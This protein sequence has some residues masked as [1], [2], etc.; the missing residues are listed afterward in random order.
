MTAVFPVRSWYPLKH[1]LRKSVLIQ[2][3][4]DGHEQRVSK[5][6]A[7]SRA[8]GQ[9][10]V[11]SYKG[12]NVFE[13]NIRNLAFVGADATS[14]ANILW[15]FYQDQ[16]GPLTPFYFYNPAENTADPGIAPLN[17]GTDTAGRYLVRF[18]DAELSRD[19]FVR[20]LYNQSLTLLEVRA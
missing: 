1:T 10:N 17:A 7:F 18:Q 12:I 20:M 2:D 14:K 8:D 13:I 11:G 5:N 9:G 16:E 19:L 15:K 6:A 3:L 4:G